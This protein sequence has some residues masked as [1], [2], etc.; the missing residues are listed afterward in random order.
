MAPVLGEWEIRTG[1][2]GNTGFNVPVLST[3]TTRPVPVVFPP[4]GVFVLE[5]RHARG[6]EM[7][8]TAHD[9]LKVL[10]PYAGSGVLVASRRLPLVAGDVAVLPPGKVHRL[11]DAGREPLSLYAICVKPSMLKQVPEAIRHLGVFKIHRRPVWAGELAALLRGLLI[12]QSRAAPGGP[13]WV[14]GFAWQLLGLLWRAESSRPSGR[15]GEVMG[16]AAL[17]R[18]RVAAYARELPQRFYEETG[19]ESAAA[20]LG[21]GRRRFSDLFREVTGESWLHAVRRERVRHARRLLA[22]TDRSVAAV[23]FESGFSDLSHFYRVFRLTSGG[24][25]PEAWRRR[26]RLGTGGT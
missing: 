5:S 3:T 18:E 19:L 15:G 14:A 22:E 9:Y 16:R 20:R 8:D 25:S 23:A 1:K 13:A 2:S 12:E 6:F 4:V 7:K 11:E 21:L 17:S 26:E 10:Y 24:L